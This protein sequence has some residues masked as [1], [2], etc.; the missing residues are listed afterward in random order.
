MKSN[1]IIILNNQ[2]ELEWKYFFKH[3]IINRIK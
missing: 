2:I 3:K 1:F